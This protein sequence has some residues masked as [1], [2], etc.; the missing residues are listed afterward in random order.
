[1]RKSRCDSVKKKKKNR[2]KEAWLA[3]S[4]ALLIRCCHSFL[5]LCWTELQENL[6]LQAEPDT[7]WWWIPD[8]IMKLMS[9]IINQ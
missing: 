7:D 3:H 8:V 1:M 9:L 4:L 6:L 5:W 2:K